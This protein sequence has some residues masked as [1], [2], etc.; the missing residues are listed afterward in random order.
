M[1]ITLESLILITEKMNASYHKIM[2]RPSLTKAKF[3]CFNLLKFY[4]FNEY[5]LLK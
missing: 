1:F 3:I 5:N 4:Q 2:V